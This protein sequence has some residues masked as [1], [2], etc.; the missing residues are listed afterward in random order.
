[1]LHVKFQ[2]LQRSIKKI[3]QKSH[4][5]EVTVVSLSMNIVQLFLHTHT[6][7]LAHPHFC[8]IGTRG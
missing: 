6:F 2:I 8:K 4:H 3:Y 7:T 5:P 1:M